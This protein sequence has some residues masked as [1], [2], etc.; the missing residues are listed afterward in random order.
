MSQAQ[1]DKLV[2]KGLAQDVAE[3][4]TN[5]G[6]DTPAKIQAASNVDLE[7]VVGSA[8]R[9]TLRQTLPSRN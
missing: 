9:A 6:Y 5:A 2:R 3:D 4:L 8:K 7:D 1:V